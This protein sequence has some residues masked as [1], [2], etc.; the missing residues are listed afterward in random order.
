M[1]NVSLPL[2]ESLH[3]SNDLLC[4]LDC[5]V[6]PQMQFVLN[7]CSLIYFDTI[8]FMI[9]H[10]LAF[11]VALAQVST[12]TSTVWRRRIYRW[13]FVLSRFAAV[14]DTVLLLICWTFNL[15]SGK[16]D[17]IAVAEHARCHNWEIVKSLRV[18]V[19]SVSMFLFT[20]LEAGH[21]WEEYF[22]STHQKHV[23]ISIYRHAILGLAGL[24]QSS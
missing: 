1:Q 16:N 24:P 10:L 18:F 15:H 11:L 4:C 12:S 3:W 6:I 20:D 23:E 9:S 2:G 14:W 7:P 13:T 21:R 5:Y 19:L 17:V 8:L 22:Q